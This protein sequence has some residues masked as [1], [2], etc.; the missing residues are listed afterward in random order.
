MALT[1]DT[2]TATEYGVV[3]TFGQ[4]D[5]QFSTLN[6]NSANPPRPP[7]FA[8]W[9]SNLLDTPAAAIPR[10]SMCYPVRRFHLR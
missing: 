7:C 6:N 2:R 5:F 1:V 9:R 3:R 10:S 8:D 4:A